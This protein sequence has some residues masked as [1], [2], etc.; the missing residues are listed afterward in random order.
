MKHRLI[1]VCGILLFTGCDGDFRTL[2]VTRPNSERPPWSIA[3]AQVEIP[4][5]ED[6]PAIVEQVAKELRLQPDSSGAARWSIRTT[7]NY[8]FTLS[9]RMDA[10]GYWV[11]GLTD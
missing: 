4:G 1:L 3:S 10:K 8:T 9:V 6:V 5:T 11:V 2:Y 7:Y